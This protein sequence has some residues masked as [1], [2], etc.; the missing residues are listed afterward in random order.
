[1]PGRR[2]SWIAAL[3]ALCATAPAAALAADEIVA[4]RRSDAPPPA[5]PSAEEILSRLEA[6]PDRGDAFE[7]DPPY[8]Q[9]KPHGAMSV[10]I[11]TGGYRSIGGEV[12]IPVGENGTVGLAIDLTQ[13]RRGY[14]RHGGRGRR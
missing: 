14:D 3:A 6:I 9:R 1:M 4:T 8:V 11:G 2:L 13:S 12:I 7:V 5:G 10:A